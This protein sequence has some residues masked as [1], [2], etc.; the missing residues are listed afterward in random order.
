MVL[1]FNKDIS[2]QE[3][4][5][6][7]LDSALK[8]ENKKENIQS[9]K[10]SSGCFNILSSMKS[11]FHD[12]MKQREQIKE[13]ESINGLNGLERKG[14]A[15][16]QA[17]SSE[18]KTFISLRSLNVFLDMEFHKG[19]LS[20]L[21]RNTLQLTK[22]PVLEKDYMNRPEVQNNPD[23]HQYCQETL[24]RLQ[25]VCGFSMEKEKHFTQP[26]A[27]YAEEYS[28]LKSLESTLEDD[29]SVFSTARQINIVLNNVIQ[30]Q[31]NLLL[32]DEKITTINQSLNALIIQQSNIN[33]NKDCDFKEY[34]YQTIK[35]AE[36]ALSRTKL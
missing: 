9:E 8:C 3:T 22:L 35:R 18:Q 31:K 32:T 14:L 28:V 1:D 16:I 11:K 34:V 29:F 7:S 10:S 20:D 13:Y 23:L 33:I 5:I 19:E 21:S 4:H 36:Y 25:N 30:S 6:L 26:T 24:N 2:F 17:C 12:F 15:D 27:L